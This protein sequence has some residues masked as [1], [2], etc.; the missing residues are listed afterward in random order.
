MSL[1]KYLRTATQLTAGRVLMWG[2]ALAGDH[3]ARILQ[4]SPVD[5]PYPHYERLRDSG[6][7]YRSKLNIHLTAN[8]A[9]SNSVLRDPRFGI[10]PA[11]EFASANWTDGAPDPESLAHPIEDSLLGLDPPDH[12]KL[13]RIASPW[14]TPRA[15]RGRTERIE[16]IAHEY[17]DQIGERDRFDLMRDFASRVPVKVICDL[18]GIENADYERMKRWGAILGDTLDGIRTMGERGQVQWAV[19]EMGEF[20]D[21]LIVRRRREPG[22]DVLS[23]LIAA[24]PDGEALSRNDLVALAGLL[25]GAGFETTVNLIGNGVLALLN[26]PEAKQLLVEE[27]GRAA[28]VTEEILR[29]DSPVQYTARLTHEPLNLAGVEL[30]ER[31]TVA[32]LLGGANRDPGVFSHPHRFDPLRANN[33]EHL[34]FSSGVH[35]CLGAGLARLE[36]EVALR[37]LFA[38]F[39]DLRQAAPARRRP[40]RTIRGVLSLPVSVGT[41]RFAAAG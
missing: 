34:S 5:N 4:V 40:S 28:D 24:R 8:H 16:Q 9:L 41:R 26:N 20:F 13:R 11:D 15:I 10:V 22:D 38:R 30:P 6:I 29:Y 31:S 7:L 39:P 2:F 35:Y 3:G 25:L 27:P 23:G 36:G 21:D 19:R 14:F 17:L 12:S 32:L 1:K 37:E 18:F 33:R